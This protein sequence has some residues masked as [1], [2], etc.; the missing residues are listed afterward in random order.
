M[1]RELPGDWFRM[2]LKVGKKKGRWGGEVLL[3]GDLPDMFS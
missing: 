1:I 3:E 2:K